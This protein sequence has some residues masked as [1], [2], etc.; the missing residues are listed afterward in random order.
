MKCIN[1]G[2]EV[3]SEFKV[4]PYCGEPVQIVPDYNIYDEDDINII[5]EGTN[6][7]APKTSEESSEEEMELNQQN[8]SSE[9]GDLNKQGED[10]VLKAQEEAKKRR[11]KITIGI[12]IGV[13]VLLVV[14][15]IIAKVVINSNNNNSYSYQMKQADSAMFKGNI[16]E[17]EE[18]YLK[19]LELEPK[20]VDVRLELA[21][22]YLEKEDSEE[23]LKLLNEV[24]EL[25]DENYTAYKLLYKI[26]SEMDDTEA[27]LALKKGVTN[28]KILALFSDYAVDAPKISLA[29]GNYDKKLK[30]T[31]SAKKDVEIYYTLDGK[32]P[33]TNGTLYKDT[34]EINEAGLHT[35]KVVTK[36]ENGVYSDIVTETYNIE[37]QAPADPVVT[38]DGGTFTKK[39]YVYI[40]VP[41]GCSAYYTWDRTDPT[42]Q[43][44]LY[45]SPIEIP[46]GDN[47]LSVII[48][49]NETGLTSGIYRGK[50]EYI[51]E[52]E[53]D[54]VE[55]DQT[56]VEE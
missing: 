15:G 53:D 4:C 52:K 19:A 28:S 25:D 9:S 43:S 36:N 48:I 23:A 30:I 8:D 46:E 26:Y 37:F 29:G 5:L 20:D 51:V 44:T 47:M 40:T 11:T 21:D 55:D 41:S 33:E 56:V 39:T 12:V 1:C 38:P 3:K 22:L 16:D 42:E 10:A 32:D 34:I 6:E 50:F 13:C 27:I 2:A 7:V 49:D 18:Y 31:L 45:V 35:L 17:A 54:T 14:A 24:L